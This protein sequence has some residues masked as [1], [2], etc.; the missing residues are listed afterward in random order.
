M[1]SKGYI[2]IGI[3]GTSFG[4]V[5]SVIVSS[6]NNAIKVLALKA[7]GMGQ[8]SRK[9]SN[10]MK[11]FESKT[12]IKAG[13]KIKIPT[14]ILHGIQDKDVEIELGKQLHQAIKTSK[15]IIFDEADHKFSRTEDFDRSIKEISEFIIKNI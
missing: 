7:A 15:I 9:M 8:T 11:H 12:W 3:C 4:G 14:L 5:A 10:Y 1:K 2:D 13:E 6:K